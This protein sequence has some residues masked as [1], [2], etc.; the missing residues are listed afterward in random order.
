MSSSVPP[1]SR[2]AFSEAAPEP[3]ALEDL[4][5]DL[6]EAA[7][8]AVEADVYLDGEAKLSAVQEVEIDLDT[9]T[10]SDIGGAKIT[11]AVQYITVEG[12]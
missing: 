7:K 2:A 11:V 8:A 4:L 1:P 12:V 9:S 5:D 6:S 10:D 3:A